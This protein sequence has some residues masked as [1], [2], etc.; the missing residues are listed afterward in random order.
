MTECWAY[1]ISTC[2]D[3]ITDFTQNVHNTE[4]VN[5]LT[6]TISTYFK[7]INLYRYKIASILKEF[8][9]HSS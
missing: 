6:P 9:T 8:S 2:L 3:I 4:T 1:H 7:P 5:C